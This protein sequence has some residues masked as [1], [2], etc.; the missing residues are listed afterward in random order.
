MPRM[1][2]NEF[3]YSSTSDERYEY[4]NPTSPA[5]QVHHHQLPNLAFNSSTS[6]QE[7][8]DAKSR[9][10]SPPLQRRQ[11]SHQSSD[12]NQNPRPEGHQ[13]IHTISS[14]DGEEKQ[15]TE[16][17]TATA[18]MAAGPDVA[19]ISLDDLTDFEGFGDEDGNISFNYK[20]DMLVGMLEEYHEDSEGLVEAI[21]VDEEDDIEEIDGQ[22]I[23]MS[24]REKT[25]IGQKANAVWY[26]HVP[27]KRKRI[28]NT[29]DP[30]TP[31]ELKTPPDQIV[32][33]NSNSTT[34]SQKQKREQINARYNAAAA[35]ANKCSTESTSE[36][37]VSSPSNP[38]QPRGGGKYPPRP[39]LLKNTLPADSFER[40]LAMIT[41]H[42]PQ[43]TLME[44]IDGWVCDDDFSDV[45]D[46]D[47]FDEEFKRLEEQ[48]TKS[49]LASAKN[50]KTTIDGEK[51]YNFDLFK[52]MILNNMDMAQKNKRS[53]GIGATGPGG[54]GVGYSSAVVHKGHEESSDSSSESS[55]SAKHMDE[56]PT[57]S[58]T[59]Q[60]Q[61]QQ[62][63][64]K[65]L[66]ANVESN[67]IKKRVAKETTK[68]NQNSTSPPA[69]SSSENEHRY[70]FQNSKKISG[71]H[72]RLPP[73]GGGGRE[74]QIHEK[75]LCPS[76]S[77]EANSQD[78][79]PHMQLK[80]NQ[81]L[82][83]ANTTPINLRHKTN[84]K[85]FNQTNKTKNSKNGLCQAKTEEIDSFFRLDRLNREIDKCSDAKKP[86]E[87][88]STTDE[89][90]TE[91]LTST[92]VLQATCSQQS[93]FENTQQQDLF[94]TP[95][96]PPKYFQSI[97]TPDDMPADNYCN[98]LPLK[99]P[100]PCS[101]I[102]SPE[103]QSNTNTSPNLNRVES[104]AISKS[105]S[106]VDVKMEH[107]EGGNNEFNGVYHQ[108]HEFCNYL[109]LTGMSTATAMANAVAEL[110]QCNLTRRSMRVL[111]Q[112]QQ[113][114]KEKSA[115]EEREMWALKEK[116]LKELK[117]HSRA[118]RIAGSMTTMESVEHHVQNECSTSQNSEPSRSSSMLK[119]K[120][121]KRDN[122]SIS[123]TAPATSVKSQPSSIP[124]LTNE[125][126]IKILCHIATSPSSGHEIDEGCS[127]IM[128]MN[129]NTPTSST[130]PMRETRQTKL[131]RKESSYLCSTT[132]KSKDH[133]QDI[134]TEIKTEYYKRNEIR[135]K[136]CESNKLASSQYAA[137]ILSQSTKSHLKDKEIKTAK[138]KTMLQSPASLSTTGDKCLDDIAIKSS[139]IR[140]SINK[141]SPSIYN[142]FNS[143]QEIDCFASKN[144]SA[145]GEHFEA[146]RAL[147][148]NSILIK[149]KLQ[150]ALVE[151]RKTKPSIFIVQ[152][153]E[154]TKDDKVPMNTVSLKQSS[155]FKNKLDNNPKNGTPSGTTHNKSP[156]K[157]KSQTQN[158]LGTKFSKVASKVAKA[159]N[160]KKVASKFL[161]PRRKSKKH[162]LS[163]SLR[164]TPKR[165][166][167]TRKIILIK[168]SKIEGKQQQQVN[169][170]PKDMKIMPSN[171]NN[172]TKSLRSKELSDKRSSTKSP[173]VNNTRTYRNAQTE[174][175]DLESFNNQTRTRL[176]A[177]ASA[178]LQRSKRR[179]SFGGSAAINFRAKML[180]KSQIAIKSPQKPEKL[181][182]RKRANDGI[183][184]DKY[185]K[186]KSNSTYKRVT[187]PPTIKLDQKD[188]VLQDNMVVSN[189]TQSVP[190]ASPCRHLQE[191]DTVVVSSTTNSFEERPTQS[192]C[193]PIPSSP[194]TLRSVHSTASCMI[195]STPIETKDNWTQCEAPNE[196]DGVQY[197]NL[198]PS[199]MKT[200]RNPLKGDH[201][202]VQYIYYEVDTLIVV[203][204]RLIS[205]WKNSRLL[206]I[207]YA[208]ASNLS[209][210][211]ETKPNIVPP[212]RMQEELRSYV[213]KTS[214]PYG[215]SNTMPTVQGDWIPLGEL[216]RLKYDEEVQ[217]PFSNRICL[218]NSTPIYVEMR[219]RQLPKNHRECNLLS[220]Y[221]NIY[222]YHD[223]EMIAKTSS[224]PLDTI[225]SELHC[226]NYTTLSDSR[227]FIMTWPQENVL[228]KTRSGL[229]KYS[230][231]PQLD[232][233]ASIRE[234]K[235]MRHTIRYLECMSD[236]KLIG[237]GDNQ[238]TVWDHRSGDVLMNYDLAIPLGKNLGSI[239]YPSQ[240]MDQNNMIILF[241][242]RD[243]KPDVCDE[244]PELL[245]IACTIT[246]TQPSYRIL[247]QQQLPASFKGIKRSINTGEHLVI[248]NSNDEEIWISC[249]NPMLMVLVPQQQRQSHRECFFSR[250]KSQLIELSE[251]ALNVDTLANHVLK[252][253]AGL[254]I[255]QNPTICK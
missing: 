213:N 231:T 3:V 140:A 58:A 147:T 219:A 104:A 217:A 42:N 126:H 138:E 76:S 71:I 111:R 103:S 192:H 196:Y 81:A 204:E 255:Q 220:M 216:N 129:K 19:S 15:D 235:S 37:P 202:Q 98:N 74:I 179:M 186:K 17:I 207:L 39:P 87:P 88:N 123:L 242:Y 226:V 61:L 54:A 31:P 18:A 230:L 155:P 146:D 249:D 97:T 101:S 72:R 73:T 251:Q 24:E 117:K 150:A 57:T 132:D 248:T 95:T 252:L 161:R 115:K 35:A 199:S 158:P 44:K 253:A 79:P 102:I 82:A 52:L 209:T 33:I 142:E 69:T 92:E 116:Q 11:I 100:N 75:I 157:E 172:S 62:R 206:N 7:T 214:N 137:T 225:Q 210:H 50:K 78:V 34:T 2:T 250:C 236:D 232:T 197:F 53:S 170:T 233:L 36:F 215:D 84:P 8:R 211:H 23:I 21:E 119:E 151:S 120:N 4:M 139:P 201:G 114:R 162:V 191:N 107:D 9:S 154:S 245:T 165:E 173:M 144:V 164:S 77:E 46:V 113:E 136:L 25:P 200:M 143:S 41:A 163:C 194:I 183:R 38:Q 193:I 109:G 160:G 118:N 122:S 16:L 195:A 153:L 85:S 131:N 152:T 30:T 176:M 243:F 180:R 49:Q 43:M 190:L 110:A 168:S 66:A 184:M 237:Y 108:Q 105:P 6:M 63:R 149:D 221:I 29:E 94:K 26:T 56:R 83:P 45:E 60:Q 51:Q 96:V 134:K 246:H 239:Y 48:R 47:K 127:N 175:S 20:L 159:V 10:R 130:M 174:T 223:E 218:H 178:L 32:E 89:H 240:E 128:T 148:P 86:P 67:E 121:K 208:A 112:Q 241:Q 133:G 224:I 212:S 145:E 59:A 222:Y 187:T 182:S 135:E 80:V 189:N 99:N 185:E 203:Q 124:M 227:Y 238:I 181:Q 55:E 90:Q 188:N 167:R 28:Q 125:P 65:T 247:Q 22:I 106:M 228:G 64:G 166:L 93:I 254:A 177:K 1:F 68:R 27:N 40:Q 91:I 5:L 141:S 205:F 13:H 244:P 156:S 171:I 12:G 198:V 234:F 169:K 70:F 229:C 14:S